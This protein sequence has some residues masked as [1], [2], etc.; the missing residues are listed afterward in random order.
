MLK[1]RT[2]LFK[3]YFVT[4]LWSG[5]ALLLTGCGF[6][7][8]GAPALPPN[9]HTMGIQSG[10]PYDNLTLQLTQ[11]ISSMGIK[12]VPVSEHPPLVMVIDNQVFSTNSYTQ[13]AS[14]STQQ[15][16]MYYNIAYHIT[17]GSNVTIL[18]PKTITLSE[19]YSLNQNQVLSTDSVEQSIQQQLQQDAVF[20]II[21]QLGS[22]DAQ[23][24]F[25]NLNNTA[26][27]KPA[28]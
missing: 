20:Q 22:Q 28:S 27:K 14:S 3:K 18:G 25:K 13:S 19:T 10:S 9:I 17:N 5:L 4:I 23:T 12:V 2:T 8:R 11:V 16:I 21:T 7:L 15:Y 24:A 1:L 26:V 6:H